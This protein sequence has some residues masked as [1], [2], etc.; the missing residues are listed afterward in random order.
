MTVEGASSFDYP[1]PHVSLFKYENNNNHI[2]VKTLPTKYQISDHI[3]SCRCYLSSP[4]FPS[5]SYRKFT[6]GI[7]FDGSNCP[8]LFFY[9]SFFSAYIFPGASCWI[10]FYFIPGFL[11]IFIVCHR[12][13]NKK[14]VTWSDDVFCWSPGDVFTRSPGDVFTRSP[15]TICLATSTHRPWSV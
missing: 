14:K 15:I 3:F 9:I 1:R 11:T 7:I 13:S 8:V 12:I 4:L 2:I 10:S 5:H 6:N